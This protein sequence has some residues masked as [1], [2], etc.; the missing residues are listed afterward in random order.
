M[1][2][3]L[4]SKIT[5]ESGEREKAKRN[6]KGENEGGEWRGISKGKSKEE[7]LR[8][9]SKM[10]SAKRGEQSGKRKEDCIKSIDRMGARK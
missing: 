4:V 6:S 2:F 7:Q 1:D 5:E 10:G 9:K 8:G 3:V